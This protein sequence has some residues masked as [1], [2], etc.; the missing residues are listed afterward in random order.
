MVHGLLH[1][2]GGGLQRLGGGR[3]LGPRQGL[4]GLLQGAGLGLAD[5]VHVGLVLLHPAGALCLLLD[6]PR[7]ADDLLLEAGQLIAALVLLIALVLLLLLVLLVL[8]GLALAED[9]FEGPDLGEVH[10]AGDPAG[11]AVRPNIL[12]PK[13]VGQELVG[14]G[15]ETLQ[16][17]QVL[18]LGGAPR[19]GL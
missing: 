8:E 11:F 7:R 2:P 9:L 13:V 4:L 18:Y 5:D 14:L 19:L 6:I 16:R 1:V 15:L 12:S 3:V 17:Q 10:V